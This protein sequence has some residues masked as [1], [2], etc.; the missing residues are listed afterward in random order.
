MQIRAFALVA[1]L[2]GSG[3]VHAQFGMS[4]MMSMMSA[5]SFQPQTMMNPY[6]NPMAAN[7]PYLNPR[8][9][10]SSLYMMMAPTTPA[11]AGYGQLA[12]PTQTGTHVLLSNDAY[13]AGYPARCQVI[14]D[15]AKLLAITRCGNKPSGESPTSTQRCTLGTRINP[16]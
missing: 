14:P 9:G 15:D 12:A 8:A 11:Y 10:M 13:S 2:V 4:P 5:Q 6:L 7:N 3:G 16:V 1:L